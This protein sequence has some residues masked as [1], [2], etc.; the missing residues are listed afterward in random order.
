M[1]NSTTLRGYAVKPMT[2]KQWQAQSDAN[3]LA[4]AA[5][6]RTDAATPRHAAAKEHAKGVSQQFAKIARGSM[7]AVKAKPATKTSAKKR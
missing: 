4:E 7:P 5:K 2:D 1:S 3:T 6:I